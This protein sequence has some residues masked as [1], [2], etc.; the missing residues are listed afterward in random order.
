M[1][2]Q[3]NPVLQRIYASSPVFLQ[4]SA[5]TALGARTRFRRYGSTFRKHDEEYNRRQWKDEEF[6][7]DYQSTA[8]ARIVDH[9][10]RT[11]EHYSDL[12]E[13]DRQKPL[14]EQLKSLPRL[15]EETLK[16]EPKTL[17]SSEHQISNCVSLSTSGTTGT[18]KTTHHTVESQCELSAAMN[19]FWRRGGCRYGDRRLSFTGNKIV[20][21]S[22]DG[23]PYGRYDRANNR[24]LMSSYHLGEETVDDYLEEID[25]FSPS[26]IDGYPSSIAFCA[27]HAV[28]TNRDIRI[29]ACFPTAETLRKED[30]ELIEEGFSTSVYNQYGS[31]ESAALVTECPC[32]RW[33][34]NPDIGIVEVVDE[35]GQQVSDG[36]I[37]ELVLTGLNNPAMP[38]I[39]YRIGD[40]ARGAPKYIECECGWNTPIIEEIIGRQDE[41]VVT[42]DGRRIPML[43]YNVFKYTD[44]IEESQIVQ[45]SV[46]EF[47]LRIV[48]GEEYA[49]EQADV[50]ILKLKDRVGSDVS[51][52]I[53]IL[54]EIPKTSS[55]KFRAVISKV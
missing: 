44:G 39:R 55:G 1:G 37:G 16:D 53:Q 2:L 54:D 26:F 32:G 23:G 50:A 17:V 19:R 22:Q 45:E 38:L 4:S 14:R 25:A 33:H 46:D 6:W 3:S 49:D 13:L 9:A 15:S 21:T 29:P 41:V 24:Y 20:P 47:T 42:A 10:R 34:V 31:T 5:V 36:E 52:T 28:E 11:T 27:Q 51:V 40:M 30:R 35:D 43:S 12:P 48:P 7:R 18:P 8:L